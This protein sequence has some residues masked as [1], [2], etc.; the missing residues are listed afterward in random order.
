MISRLMIEVWCAMKWLK[1]TRK[2]LLVWW[3]RRRW[4]QKGIFLLTSALLAMVVGIYAWAFADLPSVDNVAANMAL[5]TTRIYDRH[6]RLLYEVID[7]RGGRNIP[8]SLAEIPKVLQQATI[9]TED[10]NFYSTPGVDLEGMIRA[11][12]I[13][14]RGGEVLSGGSTITQQVARTLLFDPQQR[15]ERTLRRKL[16]EMALALLLNSRHGHD[17][18]LAMYLNQIYYGNLAYG[19]EAASKAYFSKP[20]AQLTLAESALLA[21]L[22]QSPA[23]YDPYTN[24]EAAKAR[25]KVV[26]DLMV[27]AGYIS[28]SQA[29]DAFKEPL[30]YTSAAIPMEAPH[31]VAE[32]WRQVEAQF[33][34]QIRDGGLEII[35]TLDLDLQRTG[36]DMARRQLDDLNNPKDGSRPRNASGAALVAIDPATGQILT[37][38]GSPN[39]FDKAADGAVNMAVAPRQPGSTLK[40]FTY[41]LAFDPN[42]TDPY[43][44]ATMILDVAT[45]F[46]TRELHS[47]SPSNYGLVERGPVLIRE[48][49]ASSYNIPAVVALDHVGLQPFIAFMQ[50]LG[51]TTFG[52]PDRLGLSLSLGGGEVRLTEL[53][54]AYAALARG[55]RPVKP[56]LILSVKGYDGAPLYTWQEVP[57][58]PPVIDPRV[59]WIITDILNDNDARLPSFG[60]NS[61]LR[62]GRPAAVKTGTTTDFKD[63]WTVGYT[64]QIVVG[65]WV[66]NPDNT[67][68]QN[69]SG[70]T[71]AGPLWNEFMREALKGQPELWFPRPEGI[72]SAE[73]CALSGKLP[74]PECQKTRNEWFL[75]GT[76]PTEKDDL[77]QRF[78]IDMRNGELADENTP[79]EFQRDRI[80]LI[81]PQDAWSWALRHGIPL[82]PA[83][84][85]MR[86]QALRILAPDPYTV[87]QLSPLLPFD[88]QQIKLT[89][90][91]PADTTKVEF[92][93]NDQVVGQT[94]ATPWTV[95]WALVP[96]EYQIQARV[97]LA[98]GTVKMSESIP[99]S[100][101]S[102]VPANEIP[103]SGEVN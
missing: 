21:G 85:R 4:W 33:A 65:V 56:S 66:G 76:I 31:F 53:T 36:Q 87:Y 50:N 27:V 52:A 89:A 86:Q 38:V 45:P 24:P 8:I 75:R 42:T 97:T 46:I 16:R 55:G 69:V 28:Q 34:E 39:Y 78:T 22:P 59:A 67:P 80:Y 23:T 94:Q 82:P 1:Q 18:I 6:G 54:A 90:A 25:Q 81:L 63:N 98:D 41:A 2:H 100:V 40:P 7:P 83:K 57:P 5:P 61:P 71:G 93:I 49:L 103:A 77:Y 84:S 9:A 91:V 11:L 30:Q 43:T 20:A 44:A 92:L 88:A 102:F 72:V 58:Q 95:W 73:V 62:I 19:I 37:M 14:L 68:M 32:V 29:N 60:S 15:S 96:G 64:P 26:L 10:R 47:Y 48:A 99:F 74:T 13:N 101:T 35:T 70:V 51:I 3:G 79:R 12:W 17:E